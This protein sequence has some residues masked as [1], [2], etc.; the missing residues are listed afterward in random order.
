ME[1][2][3]MNLSRQYRWLFTGLVL[4][5]AASPMV[6]EPEEPNRRQN[7]TAASDRQRYD[8]LGTIDRIDATR[9]TIVV[10]GSRTA[11]NRLYTVRCDEKTEILKTR[12]PLDF[13]QLRPEMRIWVYLRTDR[14]GRKTD[15]A[16]RLTIADPYPDVYGVITNV[17]VR[18]GTLTITR[19]EPD[20]R[21]DD[22][23][24]L[25]ITV[26]IDRKTRIRMEGRE[27]S[28]G[29]VPVGRRVA[30]TSRRDEQNQRTSVADLVSVWRESKPP[31]K[32]MGRRQAAPGKGQE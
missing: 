27:I 21:P 30:V 1:Q 4:L 5:L 23:R 28:L 19:R 18:S 17:D 29:S 24:W 8:Y 9:K 7:R 6:A 13:T 11:G 22:D 25:T 3:I 2:P 12:R 26:Q 31:E 14:D 15:V 10:R 16:R 20:T 32:E